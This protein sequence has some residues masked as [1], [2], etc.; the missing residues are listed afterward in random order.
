MQYKLIT[1]KVLDKKAIQK[2]I[3]KQ[4][5]GFT[6]EDYET[7]KPL[8]YEQ[9]IPT[10]Q[11]HIQQGSL[12]Y[13]MLVQWYLYRI[14][15]FEFE[16]NTSLHTIIAI[17]PNAVADAE[18]R[19]L[20]RSS[21]DHGIFGMPI[22]LKDNINAQGMPTTA[23]AIALKDNYAEDAFIVKQMKNKGA[24]ILGKVNLSEWAYFFCSGC[25]VGYSAIGGQ[26]LNPY[27]RTIYETGGSSA[28]SGTSMAANYA[29]AAI[30][31][32]TS[33]S[34]LSPSSQNSVVGLKP[35]IG[36]LSRSGIVPISSTLD[37]P[38]PMTRNVIDNAI[39]LSAM[40]GKDAQDSYTSLSFNEKDYTQNLE[41]LDLVGLRLG[42]NKSF[43]NNVPLYADI[44]VALQK[45]GAEVFGYEPTK[46]DLDGFLS[47]LNI[48]MRNDLPEYL[49]NHAGPKVQVRSV[50]DVMI[51]NQK[52]MDTRA[53]YDQ[54]LFAGIIADETTDDELKEIISNGQAAARAFFDVPMEKFEL[55]A[56]TSINNYDASR[57]A[58]AYY[59]ALTIPMGYQEDG[60][61]MNLTIIAPSLSEEKLLK[62]G[63]VI[64][65]ATK[66]RVPPELGK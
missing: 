40:V 37:T 24:I 50:K 5:K 59:P 12:T 30:G 47:I 35:T 7:L 23:G 39:V 14:N 49:T 18:A 15:K 11:N 19:D 45:M 33:G 54:E 38:G 52:D 27:G 25:P 44:M 21:D 60:E 10:I 31:T 43:M 29:A 22:L 53:P 17:N 46:V 32:E 4:I 3:K 65:Q 20:S 42:A 2:S 8:I 55:D 61:P 1:S 9:D 41:E 26:T 6:S 66:L 64:E 13:K 62:I 36:L 63:Y 58:I 34:I 56:I 48:D 51:F 57:A 16:P 28:G